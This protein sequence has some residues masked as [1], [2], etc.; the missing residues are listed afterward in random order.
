MLE[1]SSMAI[2]SIVEPPH[3]R[4]VQIVHS[5]MKVRCAELD[6]QVNVVWHEAEGEKDPVEASN[7]SCQELDVLLVVLLVDKERPAIDPTGPNVQ[8]GAG[9]LDPGLASHASVRRRGRKFAPLL[10]DGTWNR[11]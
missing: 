10:K 3:I 4:P 9:E 8:D 11:L 7:G 6:H 2:V 1:Q 5:E